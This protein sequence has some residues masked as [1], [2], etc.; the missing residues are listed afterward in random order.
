V[1]ILQKPLDPLQSLGVTHSTAAQGKLYWEAQQGVSSLLES[2]GQA[3][4][5]SRRREEEAIDGPGGHEG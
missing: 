2:L 3:I 1:P 4:E 5:I